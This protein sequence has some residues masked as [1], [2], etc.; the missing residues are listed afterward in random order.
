[1]RRILPTALIALLAFA[2]GCRTTE[3]HG[4]ACCDTGME[5]DLHG[6]QSPNCCAATG[7]DCG[8][9]HIRHKVSMACTVAWVD[10]DW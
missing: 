9:G 2:P 8:N 10:D 4:A 3:S 1:M 7:G 5:A 6:C